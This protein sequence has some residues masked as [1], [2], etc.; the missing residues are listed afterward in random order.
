MRHDMSS[1]LKFII[2]CFADHPILIMLQRANGNDGLGQ[3]RRRE[4]SDGD[5]SSLSDGR[6]AVRALHELCSLAHHH[7][8]T[9]QKSGLRVLP[10]FGE[11]PQMCSQVDRGA[12]ANS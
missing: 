7:G 11:S 4:G 3:N 9:L 12:S 1:W 5:I 6:W 10:C 8:Q 2:P